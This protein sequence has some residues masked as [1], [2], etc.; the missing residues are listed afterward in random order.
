[1]SLLNTLRFLAVLSSFR[2]LEP[3][4]ANKRPSPRAGRIS[5]QK[6]GVIGNS[7]W[8]KHMLAIRGAKAANASMR[9]QGRT[10]GDEGR[11]AIAR[12]RETRKHVYELEE[13]YGPGWRIGHTD[14]NG[15]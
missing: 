12:N 7:A 9:A 11:A 2:K 1:M 6:R 15:I 14:L 13:K 10:P 5:A 4:L 3:R 8:G